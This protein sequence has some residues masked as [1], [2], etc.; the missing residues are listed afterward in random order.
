MFKFHTNVN[1]YNGSDDEGERYRLCGPIHQSGSGD[2]GDRQ[3]YY[4]GR[5]QTPKESTW[6]ATDM[7]F[8]N[9]EDSCNYIMPGV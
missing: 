2:S 6:A 7:L 5:V 4:A 3:L 1:R 9:M 8:V